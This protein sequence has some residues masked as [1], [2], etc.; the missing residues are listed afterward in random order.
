MSIT[1]D[2]IAMTIT[3]DIINMAITIIINITITI[4]G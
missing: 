3:I 2:I 4:N 1:I